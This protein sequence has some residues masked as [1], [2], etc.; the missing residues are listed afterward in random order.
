[1]A[2]KLQVAIVGL[3]LI[4]ASAGLALRRFQDRV[5]VIGHD[6]DPEV[7]GRAKKMGAVDRTEWNLINTVRTA[8]R[9]I[10]ALP[11]SEMRATFEAI[12]GELKT[13]C[14]VMDTASVKQPVMNWANTLLPDDTYFVGGHPIVLADHAALEGARADLFDGKLFCLTPDMHT[15]DTAVRLASDVAEALGARPYFLDAVEHD[16]LIAAVEHL[17]AITAAALMSLVT[18]SSGWS[19]MRKLAGSQ[20]F[21]STQLAVPS[22]QE[23]VDGSFANRELVAQWLDRLMDELTEWRERLVAGDAEEAAKEVDRGLTSGRKWMWAHDHGSW[24]EEA[25]SADLPTAGSTMRGM[26]FG[27]LRMQPEKSKRK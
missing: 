24:D 4:G 19:D 7:A 27:R 12:A 14:V 26:L 3:G 20:F 10:L 9:V 18:D 23:A 16:G 21:L 8:D 5:Y 25:P 22:G 6:R 1:M 11:L 15:N 17:P 13:G 2:E